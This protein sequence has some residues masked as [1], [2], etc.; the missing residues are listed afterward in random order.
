MPLPINVRTLL[1]AKIFIELTVGAIVNISE[2][3]KII[4]VFLRTQSY[5]GYSV[6]LITTLS[7]LQLKF[8]KM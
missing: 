5:I 2:S 3:S 4:R 1:W 7:S 8:T 6:S